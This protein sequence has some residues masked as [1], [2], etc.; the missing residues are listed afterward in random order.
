[1]HTDSPREPAI[2]LKK[3][4]AVELLILGF[5]VWLTFVLQTRVD[6]SLSYQSTARSLPALFILLTFPCL[7]I[8]HID[9]N[10]TMS[11]IIT[12][13][14][15]FITGGIALA[16]FVS[17]SQIDSTKDLFPVAMLVTIA[18]LLA[19]KLYSWKDSLPKQ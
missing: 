9:W 15:S 13:I 8:L 4:I 7:S 19:G 17:A 6:V 1:M 2:S 11:V 18:G 3:L 10:K 12:F 16:G 5:C 14:V